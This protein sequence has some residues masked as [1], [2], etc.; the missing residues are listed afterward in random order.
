[1][2]IDDGDPWLPVRSRNLY[3]KSPSTFAPLLQTDELTLGR[4]ANWIPLHS[5]LDE[6]DWAVAEPPIGPIQTSLLARAS[7]AEGLHRRLFPRSRRFDLGKGPLKAIRD[8][9]RERGTELFKQHGIDDKERTDKCVS[10]ALNYMNDV[11]FRDRVDEMVGVVNTVAPGVLAGV[12][13]FSRQLVRA[14]NDLAHYGEQT[15]AEPFEAR[16]DRWTLFHLV[17]PWVL[18]ILLLERAGVEPEVLRNALDE[19]MA[20]AYYR[21]NVASIVDDLCWSSET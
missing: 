5:K 12:P 6:L 19:S 11:S 9:L 2:Q 4:L 1:M 14:R 16:I 13:D 8:E 18:R 17:I 15:A 7:V 3:A 21:A 20:F 10:D